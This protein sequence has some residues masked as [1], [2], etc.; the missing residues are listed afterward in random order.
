MVGI[1]AQTGTFYLPCLFYVKVEVKIN[2]YLEISTSDCGDK[3]FKFEQ[4]KPGC[5]EYRQ[6]GL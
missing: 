6:P 3:D 4:K 2:P 1:K 5:P